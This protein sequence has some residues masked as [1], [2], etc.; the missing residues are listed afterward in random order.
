MKLVIIDVFDSFTYNLMHICEKYV[1]NVEVIRID[2]IK[3]NELN[4]FHKI[5]LS[6]GP[7][8]PVDYPNL[9][10]ILDK[11]HSKKD[12]LGICLGCQ[13]IA[14]FF[15]VDLVNLSNVMHGKKTRITHF[16]NDKV[17]YNGIPKNFFVG[18][19]H[20][21]VVKNDKQNKILISSTDGEKN[22]MS[23]KHKSLKIRGIQ[24]H[25]ESILTDFGDLIIKNWI[26][27]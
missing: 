3:I 10:K 27:S 24:Y 23:F 5:I 22:I 15:G 7:G 11:Y 18:R 4:K 2:K 6:P 8:L 21:W 14:N 17:L 26:S 9:K 13:A 1:K 12:I 16:E 25:P 19:Y 20:S